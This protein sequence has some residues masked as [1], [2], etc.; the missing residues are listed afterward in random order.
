MHHYDAETD[1]LARAVIDTALSR[2]RMDPPPLDGPRTADELARTAGPTITEEGLGGAE[3]LRVL[4]DVLAPATISIDHPRFLAF[5]PA[6]PTEAAVLAD[7]IVGAS[8]IYAGSWMEGAGAVYAENVALRFLADEIGFPDGAGGVFVSGGTAGNL[9]ALVAARHR[10]R[11]G[12]TEQGQSRPHRWSIV[13]SAEAHSSIQAAADVMDCD[14]ID[15]PVDANAR[16][17]GAAVRARLEELDDETR[18]GIFAVVATGGTTNLGVVDDLAGVA[19]TCADHDL[20]FH[21]DGAYGGAALLAPSAR[22]R[23]AGIER[24]DS[25]IVDPHKW[26]FAP[27]DSCALL[28]RDPDAARS[29]H[30]Q[31][32]GYLDV[33]TTGEWNPSDFAHHLSRRARGVPFWF[34]LATHGVQAYRDAIEQALTLARDT[35]ALVRAHPDLELVHEPELSVVAF[36]RRGWQK[37][38]YDAWSDRI[39]RRG[40]AFVVPTGTHEGPALRFCFINPRTTITDVELI[41]GTLD[42]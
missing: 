27:F 31:Q 5:V 18:D 4:R 24:A 10:A 9:S 14:I 30:T 6:A 3:A 1:A 22:P 16:L 13:G 41:L 28:Y 33:L 8:S 37:A 2:V 34:S 35:A 40:L 25:F 26:L 19:E 12:R 23:F 17:T 11:A 21:V 29:A 32:A 36:R 15:V 20:W 42:D 39:L 38:A 7:L